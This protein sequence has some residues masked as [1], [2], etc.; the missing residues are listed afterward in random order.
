M[1]VKA[2][3]I[4]VLVGV[5]LVLCGCIS[6]ANKNDASIDLLVTND[7]VVVSE[8]DKKV[9]IQ[10]G[11]LLKVVVFV[12][13]SIEISETSRVSE[14]GYMSLP[15]V[16]R[17]M[18]KGITVDQ[19]AQALELSYAE[20]FYVNP[21]VDVSFI[22]EASDGISPWGFVTVL[23][24]VKTPGRVSIPATNDMTLTL[25]IQ[26]AGG[27]DTSAKQSAIRITR[28]TNDGKKTVLKVDINRVGAKGRGEEDLALHPGDVIYV[29]ETIF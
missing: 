5:Q 7:T 24:R 25:A 13:G 9:V 11:L 27:L 3:I 29:P 21:T 18:A 28:Q 19:L 16:G 4:Y 17:F 23:G 6:T 12:S 1:L 22:G 8:C 26:C 20:K 2:I 10:S 15:L 14:N